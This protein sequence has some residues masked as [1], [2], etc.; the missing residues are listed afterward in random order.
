M[1]ENKIDD[2]YSYIMSIDTQF[3]FGYQSQVEG[4]LDDSTCETLLVEYFSEWSEERLKDGYAKDE[5]ID[6]AQTAILNAKNLIKCITMNDSK[7]IL[8]G[9]S[10][11]NAINP[12]NVANVVARN[13]EA[14][15][16]EQKISS[17][18]LN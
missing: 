1:Q 17:H 15:Q 12:T 11:M 10:N 16:K 8:S 5:L 18:S 13:I 7:I 6:E 2:P 3:D 4:I 9:S 14:Q